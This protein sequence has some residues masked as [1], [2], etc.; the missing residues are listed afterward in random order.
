MMFAAEIKKAAVLVLSYDV[1]RGVAAA[2]QPKTAVVRTV[3]LHD[4]PINRAQRARIPV[5]VTEPVQSILQYIKSGVFPC[6]AGRL[7]RD[8]D[9][10]A[11]PVE[12]NDQVDEKTVTRL[13]AIAAD[14]RSLARRFLA[15]APICRCAEE[16]NRG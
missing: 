4:G 14:R 11:S 12:V 13:D 10:A 1:I 15:V 8:R 9:G 7:L 16:E 5:K 6:K 3:D 2:E